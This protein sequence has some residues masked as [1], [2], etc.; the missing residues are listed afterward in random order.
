MSKILL[1]KKSVANKWLGVLE[2]KIKSINMNFDFI[3]A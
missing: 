1:K 2:I 3:S